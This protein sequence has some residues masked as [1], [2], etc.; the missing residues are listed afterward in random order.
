[1]IREEE[2]AP[3]ARAVREP[4]ARAMRGRNGLSCEGKC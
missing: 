1:M 4:S 3:G 2:A